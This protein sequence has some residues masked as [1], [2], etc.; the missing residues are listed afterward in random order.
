MCPEGSARWCY[1]HWF[2]KD[3]AG[4]GGSTVRALG[5]EI[6]VLTGARIGH[7]LACL[8][9]CFQAAGALASGLVR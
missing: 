6:I 2:L 3:G 4:W 8:E 9:K 7:I 1:L 5:G